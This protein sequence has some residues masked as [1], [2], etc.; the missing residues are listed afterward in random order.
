MN[1]M[2]LQYT[3]GN[4]I[5][6]CSLNGKEITKGHYICYTEYDNNAVDV[7]GSMLCGVQII[8]KDSPLKVEFE[9]NNGWTAYHDVFTK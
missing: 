2:V 7:N 4:K 8:D 6:K 1:G 9:E 5:V 3:N